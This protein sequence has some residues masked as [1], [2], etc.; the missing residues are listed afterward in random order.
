MTETNTAQLAAELQATDDAVRGMGW[1]S[2]GL[3]VPGAPLGLLGATLNPLSGLAAAG[4]AWFTPLVSF[5]G[6][7]LIQLQGGNAASVTSGSQDFGAAGR[8]IAGVADSYRASAS[9][10]TSEWS[11]SAASAYRDAGAQYAD[12]IAGLGQGSTTTGSAIL[13]AGQVV[14]QAIAE[15]TQLIAEAVAEIV[16]IMTQAV[17]RAPETFGQSVVEAI[18]PCVGIAVT[19]AA[20]IAAKLAALIASGDNLMKLVQGGMA[21]VDLIQQAL[22]GISRQSVSVEAAAG[23]G[24]GADQQG[25]GRGGATSAMDSLGAPASGA[26]SPAPTSSAGGP[27]M[28]SAGVP[29]ASGGP[30]VSPQGTHSW[31][32]PATYSSALASEAPRSAGPVGGG[33]LATSAAPPLRGSGPVSAAVPGARVGAERGGDT[34]RQG[35]G[36]QSARTSGSGSGGALGGV[37][38]GALGGGRAAGDADKEHQRKYE[39][40][41][42]HDEV[43]DATS[44]V[45]TSSDT[46]DR[47]S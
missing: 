12:G 33:G 31:T 11:G 2:P 23:P 39:L 14:A 1:V 32:P 41:E 3:G 19:Y 17:A 40:A 21:V 18:P 35:G 20:R 37:P 6:D 24:A 22:H 16:P 7:G 9:A 30:V 34:A 8:D 38:M 26:G 47:S 10:Q 4:L 45:I 43:V 29:S 36:Q 42:A 27:S 15:V 25:G 13:G 5:L 44:P 46:K 28:S